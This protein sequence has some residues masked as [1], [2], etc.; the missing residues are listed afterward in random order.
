MTDLLK[1]AQDAGTYEDQTD[2]SSGGFTREIV[3]A[4]R[5]PAR[6][7]G[8]VEVG[9]QP[10]TAF[11]SEEVKY[12]D[13]VHVTF[14]VFGTNAKEIVVDGETKTVGRIITVRLQKKLNEKSTYTK[15]FEAMRDSR[16]DVTHMAS[17]LDEVFILD[18]QHEKS[19]KGKTY[20]TLDKKTSNGKVVCIYPPVVFKRD[21]ETDELTEEISK[22]HRKTCPKASV[23]FRLFLF[24]NPTQEQWASI[25]IDGEYEREVTEA[26]GTKTKE[27]V[28][29]NFIQELVMSAT[30][31]P[32]S[33]VESL[34]SGAVVAGDEEATIPPFDEPTA[35]EPKKKA[36]KPAAEA[37]DD[38][39]ALL[40]EV[41]GD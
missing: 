13:T 6:L 5:N 33:A 22:D 32:G 20:A 4:G 31:F 25:H 15:Y 10:H 39:D 19:K 11:E 12:V 8:Y 38:M 37:T 26:D 24:N 14:E 2:T 29:K 34:V 35:E 1:Q 17:M 30:D 23:G 7:V 16:E 41:L 40:D 28:S 21:P 3:N 36:T 9:K 18:V 27:T